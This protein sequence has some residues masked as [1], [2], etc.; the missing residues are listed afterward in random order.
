[1]RTSH[2]ILVVMV[3]VLMFSAAG[4]KKKD[5]GA[6]SATTSESAKKKKVSGADKAQSKVSSAPEAKDGE[7]VNPAVTV[8]REFDR[9][10]HGG[11]P[12]QALRAL[13]QVLDGWMMSRPPPLSL[14][15]MVLEGMLEKI[16]TAPAGKKYTIDP[17]TKR[18]VLANE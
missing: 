8:K 9:Q 7:V 11:N 14:E 10:L 12:Q 1:M 5:A 16:P 18:V 15:E 17:K 13:N 3:F 6:A 4:C 2:V